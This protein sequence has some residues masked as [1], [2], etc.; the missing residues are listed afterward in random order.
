MAAVQGTAQEQM[1]N[2]ILEQQQRNIDALNQQVQQLSDQVEET[3]QNVFENAQRAGI[4]PDQIERLL[5]NAPIAA[6]EAGAGTGTGGIIVPPPLIPPSYG[7]GSS[8]DN[9]S[10]SGGDDSGDDH[11]NDGDEKVIQFINPFEAVYVLTGTSKEMIPLPAQVEVTLSNDT[12][13]MLNVSWDSGTPEYDPNQAGTYEFTGTIDLVEGITNPGELKVQQKVYVKAQ[14]SIMEAVTSPDTII[15]EYGTTLKNIPF[16]E[17]IEVSLS[18]QTTETLNVSWDGG[19]PEYDPNQAGTYEFIG[20]I[21]LVIW[22]TN[23]NDL[24]ARLSVTVN[25]QK[26]ATS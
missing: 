16:P 4:D 2:R 7:G 13:E 19:T 20:T 15:V 6:A 1:M 10:N 22:I 18:D 23:P 8:N 26:P 9:D 12:T 21:D 14:Q 3:R 24:K 11:N 5:E 17:Q 25:Q